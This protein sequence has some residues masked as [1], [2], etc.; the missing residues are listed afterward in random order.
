MD[1]CRKSRGFAE[2]E[3]SGVDLGL[4]LWFGFRIVPFLMFRSWA[5]PKQNLDHRYFFSLCRYVNEFIQIISFFQQSSF[6]L[7]RETVIGVV[8]CYSHQACCIFY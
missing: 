8:M 4:N 1:F 3:N 7:R 5:S 2:F 6:K